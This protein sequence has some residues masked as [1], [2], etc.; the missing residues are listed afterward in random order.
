MTDRTGT[1][2]GDME[3][4]DTDQAD[5]RLRQRLAHLEEV[6]RSR[7][8]ALGLIR[9]LSGFS[10]SINRLEKPEAILQQCREQVEKLIGIRTLSFFLIDEQTADFELAACYPGDDRDLVEE[11]LAAFIE[12]GTFSR[13]VLEKK[14]VTAASRDFS[15]H[16]LLHVLAT[17]S[18]TRGMCIAILEGSPRDLPEAVLELFS[19]LMTHCANALETYDLYS[20]VRE[21]NRALEEKVDQL[22]AS[23]ASLRKEVAE[24]KKTLTA[25]RASESRYRLLSETARELILKV[26]C[27]EKILYVNAFGLALS[28]FGNR[29]LLGEDVR[30]LLPS[31]GKIRDLTKG[32]REMRG[33][34]AE[35]HL[36]C[37]DGTPVPMEISLVPMTDEQREPGLLLMG[38]DI[39]ERRKAEREKQEL[40]Q[41]L[42]QS[43]KMESIGLMAGGTAHDFNNVL[44][45]ILNYTDLS[46]ELTGEN[47]PAARYLTRVISATKQ[48]VNLSEKLYAL[49]RED[50]HETSPLDLEPLMWETLKLI[51]LSMGQ[52]LTLEFEPC[53]MQLMVMGEETRLR[54]V[55]MNLITNA[56]HAMDHRGTIMVGGDR[57]VLSR[58]D[59]PTPLDIPPGSYIR[60]RV[61]DT[62]PGIDPD[63]LPR[64]FE[65]Y[66]STKEGGSNAGLGLAV[67]HGIVRNYGGAVTVE[68]TPGE[69]TCFSVY[70][71]EVTPS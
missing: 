38:R 66:Y 43:R 51:R 26:S 17:V 24:H 5:I 31:F 10:E 33:Q 7:V 20:R 36:I 16:F 47:H 14:P 25:L 3:R 46:L 65:P 22:S 50:R 30:L 4:G 44:S 42:W 52:D 18:R 60:F 41:R 58:S 12:D 61:A 39:T 29:D 59:E 69:G 48:A 64:I 54:Q 57:I 37:R 34:L 62:G 55:L 11:E 70:L 2:R 49:G 32:R 1:N 21:T 45:I 56:A 71:P 15:S 63:A 9:E 67:V 13:A 28:G 27:K 8:K 19:I 35:A 6:N 40:E 68:S 23:Q 53:G